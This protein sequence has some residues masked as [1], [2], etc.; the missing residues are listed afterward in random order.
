MLKI[1]DAQ[2]AIR[3]DGPTNP[4]KTKKC[5][6]AIIVDRQKFF[7]EGLSKSLK[8]LECEPAYLMTIVDTEAPTV[9][10]MEIEYRSQYRLEL[11]RKIVRRYPGMLAISKMRHSFNCTLLIRQQPP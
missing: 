2:N 5:I 11:C 1:T 6:R 8:V 9:I 4:E 3:P 10:M 7:R